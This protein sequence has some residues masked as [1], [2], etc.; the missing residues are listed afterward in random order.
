MRFRP[1]LL[2]VPEA[3]SRLPCWKLG[4]FMLFDILELRR[5]MSWMPEFVSKRPW[6][7]ADDN[8]K[9]SN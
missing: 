6:L 8:R 4:M 5:C 7:G 2:D 9:S 3:L 1:P